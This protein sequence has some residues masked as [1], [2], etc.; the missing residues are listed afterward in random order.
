MEYQT[1]SEPKFSAFYNTQSV[2]KGLSMNTTSTLPAVTKDLYTVEIIL[3]MFTMLILIVM[4]T[5][6]IYAIENFGTL[7]SNEQIKKQQN[8]AR[9]VGP[10]GSG[11]AGVIYGSIISLG[12]AIMLMGYNSHHYK[13]TPTRTKKMLVWLIMSTLVVGA[14]TAG[15][16]LHFVEEYENITGIERDPIQVSVGENYKIRGNYGNALLALNSTN[17]SLASLAFLYAI[18]NHYGR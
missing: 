3:T 1:F 8:G 5:M 2:F 6:V 12:F 11:M 9:L 14:A 17:V 18:W 10:Y 13:G 7:T 15:L 4:S 16:N